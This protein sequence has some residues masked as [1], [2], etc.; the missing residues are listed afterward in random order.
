MSSPLVMQNIGTSYNTSFMILSS[1]RP[2]C[3][4]KFFIVIIIL[5]LS[6]SQLKCKK[7]R[8]LIVGANGN[9][10]S[11]GHDLKEIYYHQK[12]YV[13]DNSNVDEQQPLHDLFQKCIKVMLAINNLPQPVIASVQGVAT[14][15]GC[16]L[17]ASCDL[18]VAAQSACFGVSGINA[19]L[20]CSTPAVALSRNVGRKRAMHMLLTGDLI[21]ADEAL[22]Y[23]LVNKVVLPERLGEETMEL[24]TK[25]A[26]KSDFGIRLGKKM[27]YE[28][29]K[30]NDLGDAYEFAL[31][32][33]VCNIGHADARDG[34]DAFV[35]KKT[36]RK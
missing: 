3:S 2:C 25:I 23:G 18:A 11:S 7:T 13:N 10:F 17:V 12:N 36:A 6:L 21:S 19:G 8:V 28:Q 22:E 31:E 29:L 30:F 32:R 14:A 27:F 1:L 9:A 26:R 35:N 34:I 4:I 5:L 15:A 16:Q 33:M 20:F 24:A